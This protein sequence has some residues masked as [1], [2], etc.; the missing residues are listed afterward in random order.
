MQQAL[1]TPTGELLRDTPAYAA[2]RRISPDQA[3]KALAARKSTRG[4]MIL[5]SLSFA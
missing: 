2:M 5:L 3:T 1:P 4:R